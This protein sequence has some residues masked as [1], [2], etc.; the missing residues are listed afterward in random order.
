[1]KTKQI[2][3]LAA[4]A[5]LFIVTGV[6]SVLTHQLAASLVPV[7][8]TGVGL[9]G[10]YTFQ[11][12]D[13]DYIGV[14]QVKGTIGEQTSTTLLDT[15]QTYQHTTTLEYIDCLMQDES[16]NGILLDVDSPGGAVYESEELYRKLQEYKQVTGR[17]IWCYMGHYAASGGYYVSAAADTIYA[18]PNTTTGSI[19]VIMSA[20]DMTGLYDKLGIRQEN[21]TSGPFKAG[22]LTE[23]QIAIYQSQVDESYDRFVEVVAEGR[24]MDE[25]AVRTLAD[26][27]TYTARQALDNGLIDQICLYDEAKAAISEESGVGRFYTLEAGPARL[28][29][30]LLSAVDRV[31]PKSE[32]QVLTELA[33]QTQGGLMYYADLY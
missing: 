17:P 7:Q 1:M 2:V 3:G 19:G 12:P 25:A 16:K 9:T 20:V 32:A 10:G 33:Q 30:T 18:N 26:G 27:R 15:S 11:A 21:I 8:P 6:S 5:A 28:L 31:M 24:G 29:D 14:V 22:D 23:E 4:A 13:E